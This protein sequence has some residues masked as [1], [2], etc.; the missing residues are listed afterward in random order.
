MMAPVNLRRR[1]SDQGDARTWMLGSMTT[2]VAAS[3]ARWR[4][5]ESVASAIVEPAY[6][7]LPATTD[8]SRAYEL[9]FAVPRP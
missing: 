4:L 5:I 6:T 7:G 1:S 3:P 8:T 9:A 2:H